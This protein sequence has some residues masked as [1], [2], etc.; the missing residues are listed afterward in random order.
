MDEVDSFHFDMDMQM[1]VG[2]Q[3]ATLEVPISFVGDYQAPD[4]SEGTL[5]VRFLLFD[6][7]SRFVSIGDTTY[8]TDPDTGEWD[9]SSGPASPF[10]GPDEFG[11]RRLP[12]QGGELEHQIT[13]QN[14]WDDRMYVINEL[15]GTAV[16]I[17]VE[18][19]NDGVFGLF[20]A[21]GSP[22][23]FG[24]EA[25]TGR[26]SGSAVT[27]SPAPYFLLVGQFSEGAGDFRL[28]SNRSLAAFHDPDDGTDIAIGQTIA[29]AMDYP[30]DGDYFLIDLI[31]G[32]AV[33]ITVDSASLD[34]FVSVDF[35]GATEAELVSDDDSGGGLFGLNAKVTYKAPHSGSYVVFVYDANFAAVGGYFLA[36]AQAPPGAVPSAPEAR[37]PEAAIESPFGPM[38]LYESAQYPFSI[39][40][41]SGWT[42]QPS[43]P[44]IG[45]IASFVSDQGS[46]RIVEED[47]V[48]LG[49]GRLTLEAYAD[50]LLS[51]VSQSTVGYE[52]VSREPVTTEQRLTAELV[53]FTVLSGAIKYTVLIYLHEGRIGFTATYFA[54][55]ARLEALR[56]LIDYSFSTFQVQEQTPPAPA[57]PTPPSA[58]ESISIS[59]HSV[60]RDHLPGMVLTQADFDSEYPGLPLDP[61]ESGY[62]DNEA[63]ADLTFDPNNSASDLAARGRLEGYALELYDAQILYGGETAGSRLFRARSS[64]A[65]FDSEVS[66]KAFN[67]REIEDVRRFEGIPSE[68]ATR[69]GFQQFVPP[70]VGTDAVAGRFSLSTFGF[71]V[72][73]YITFVQ[74]VRGH[75]ISCS[76]G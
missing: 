11:E 4:R 57:T 55:P 63:A 42:E 76:L 31:K 53:E 26:E 6:I 2:D 12:F 18:G 15:A 37:P 60:T 8:V 71:K 45:L 14:R 29:A 50:I 48:S 22:L 27:Q 39:Q 3:G 24:D 30:S 69:T 36:V 59:I 16:D 41:P 19:E 61:D 1:R 35:L 72:L 68:G 43:Q 74:W 46:F 64:V 21:A 67:Q 9:I 58:Q 52:L 38:E 32:D 75:P 44:E 10:G 17:D 28:S 7:E 70:D 66:A 73:A 34:P 5:S 49:V 65:L 40:F 25:P 20:D 13:L 56:P 62:Q 33:D 51:I 47:M 54:L 23:T